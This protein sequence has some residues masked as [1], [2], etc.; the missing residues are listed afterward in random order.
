MEDKKPTT[1]ENK[2]HDDIVRST[3]LNPYIKNVD[4]LINWGLTK[5]GKGLITAELTREQIEICVADALEMYT[6]YAFFPT[7]DLVY[8]LKDYQPEK[9]LYLG[10]ENVAAVRDVSFER[11]ALLYGYGDL[12]FGLPAMIQSYNGVFP[13]FNNGGSYYGCW[14][15]LHN[16]HENMEMIHRMTGS[17]PQYRYD[18]ATKFLVLSPEPNPKNNTR[19]ILVQAEVEP[20]PEELYGNYYVR[21]IF[22]A[23]LKIQL[24]IIR[25][26]FGS[27]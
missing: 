5:L 23:M 14:V 18:A 19:H 17:N 13:F 8:P 3:Y 20:P 10:N 26:K 7:K 9:G 2:R 6:R 1:E 4:D 11:D 25:K 12:Y 21:R 16:L 22:L 15:S 24:G 27:V